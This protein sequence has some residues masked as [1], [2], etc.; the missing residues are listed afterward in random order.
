M[1]GKTYVIYSTF[2]RQG[3]F[4][5]APNLSNVNYAIR[6]GLWKASSVITFHSDLI[7]QN[8]ISNSINLVSAYAFLFLISCKRNSKHSTVHR[9]AYCYYLVQRHKSMS[10]CICKYIENTYGNSNQYSFIINQYIHWLEFLFLF[11]WSL[12]FEIVVFQ[13]AGW[14]LMLQQAPNP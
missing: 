4:Y 3:S 14:T 12:R 5:C 9:F 8:S 10:T 7:N 11:P 2:Y 1:E 13:T 6:T